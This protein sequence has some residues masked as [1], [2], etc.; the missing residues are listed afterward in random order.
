VDL[1]PANVRALRSDIHREF[2]GAFDTTPVIYP[3]I[4][5]TV[6]SSSS[7]NDY[8]W[9]TMLPQMREWVGSRVVQ[10]LSLHTYAIENKD[11]EL[12]LGVRRNDIEDDN[13]GI[14]TP[15]AQQFG[16]AARLHPDQLLIDLLRTGHQKVCFDGQYF[17]DTDHPVNSVDTQSGVYSNFFTATPLTAPNYA[18]V[19][20]SMLGWKG[21]NGLSLRVIPNLLVVGPGLE[22]TAK[23]IVEIQQEANGAGN[24]FYGTA[25]VLVLPELAGDDTTWYL[26]TTNRVIKP[27]IFQTRRPLSF[28]TKNQITDEVVLIENEVRFYADARYNAGYSLPFLAAKAVA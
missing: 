20:A 16:E 2:R 7:K 18:T 9:M 4:A 8:A 13:L 10:N 3:E 21:E 12:T 1:T 27:F 22:V 17:F 11:W 19:R 24:P 5:T 6:P 25:R 23:R 28:V 14:Y 26:M 15:V